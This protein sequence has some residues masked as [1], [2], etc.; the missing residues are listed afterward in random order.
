MSAATSDTKSG[1]LPT[2]NTA[3]TKQAKKG[4]KRKRIKQSPEEQYHIERTDRYNKMHHACSKLLHREAKV[5]KSFECQKIVRAIK[6]ANDALSANKDED[7]GEMKCP[8]NASKLSKRVQTLQHKLDRTKK[9]DLEVLV[10]VGLKRLGVSS[11]DPRIH[12]HDN[13]NDD[14]DDD[15][16]EDVN[17]HKSQSQHSDVETPSQN[18]EDPFYQTLLETML[19]HKRLSTALDQLNG[20]VT[21]YRQWAMYRER[22]LRGE[23]GSEDNP[24][25]GGKKKNKKK[26]NQQGKTAVT[27]NDTM[28]VAGGFN[29]RKRGLDLGGHEGTSG[30]F[31]GSLSGMTA[32]GY[33]DGGN[34][35]GGTH[36]E[37]G[38]DEDY[39][40]Q[41][42]KKK[43]RPGQ[44]AR[45]AKAQA[46]EARKEGK[47]WDS[48]I[49]WRE[50]KMNRADTKHVK[51]GR[52]GRDEYKSKTNTG[53]YDEADGGAK[54]QEAQHIAAMGKTWKE[55]GN[56]HPSWA[57]AAAQKS[58][59]IKDFLGKKTTFD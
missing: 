27:G 55:D 44:R 38:D 41:E 2:N 25:G 31:I 5:V 23:D 45:R 30:L 47:T 53:R 33:E 58:Q 42:E 46:I 12:A 37:E 34:Y 32:E 22:M 3:S 11:L 39:G 36:G 1:E 43:N 26:K 18:N 19:Q 13:D 56:A 51:G 20:R 6:A 4:K 24:T 29:T 48:S 8:K 28:V 35:M 14:K 54:P 16:K 50:K 7:D 40:Y 57:A 10:Q 17:T 15:G 52:E 49:N 59:G 9:M 21:E